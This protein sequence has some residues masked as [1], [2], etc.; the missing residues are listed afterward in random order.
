[1]YK[2][3]FKLPLCISVLPAHSLDDGTCHKRNL[4]EAGWFDLWA[5]ETIRQCI[6]WPLGSLLV[7]S[8]PVHWPQ[9]FP[10]DY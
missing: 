4:V 7:G 3:R 8:G 5:G 2:V 6:V 1:M 10:S 9:G